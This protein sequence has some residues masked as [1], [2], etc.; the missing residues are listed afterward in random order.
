M[1]GVDVPIKQTVSGKS[2]LEEYEESLEANAGG[3][4]V[5][6]DE[7]EEG[8]LCWETSNMCGEKYFQ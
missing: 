6:D 3:S 8:F 4:G 5:D 7:D 1:K 2:E